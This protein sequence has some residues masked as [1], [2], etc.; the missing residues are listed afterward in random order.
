M[1]NNNNQQLADLL[2]PGGCTADWYETLYAPRMLPPGAAVTRLGPSPTGF[3]HLGNLF[4][5]YVNKKLAAQSDGVFLLRVEDTDQKRE[6]EGAAESLITALAYFGIRAEEGVCFE[7]A[8]GGIGEQGTYGPYFQS[9]RGDIYHSFAKKLVSEGKAYPCFLTEE[10]LGLIRAEQERGK[11]PTGIYGAYAKYRGAGADEVKRRI[12][13]GERY[14]LRLYADRVYSGLPIADP[15]TI[16]VRDGIRGE[17]ALPRNVMDVVLLKTDGLPTYHFAHTVDDHLMR[18]THVVRGEEWLSS[19]PIHIALFEA[20]GFA[21]PIYC[22]TALLMKMDGGTKRKLSKRKDPELALSYY[23]AEGYHP[24]AIEEYL[25]TI[26]N[27]NYE[28]WREAHPDAKP[29]D[30]VMTTEKMGV[31]GILFD[32]DKLQNISKDVLAHIPAQELAGFLTEWAG[33]EKP[34]ALPV[35]TREWDTLVRALDVGRGGDKPRKDLSYAKQ[36]FDFISYFFD[37]FFR[38]EDPMPENVPAEDVRAILTDYLASYDHADARDVWFEK[39]R[40]IAEAHGYAAKPK[41]YKKEP[42]RYKGHVGDVSTVIRVALVGRANSPDICEIQQILGEA[43]VRARIGA[44][45]FKG[46]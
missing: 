41:D 37:E 2:F 32:L 44:A 20:L 19:L 9:E 43:R 36:I 27:S 14:V 26:I 35:L 21:P 11:L 13:A 40:G 38:R 42:E 46:L 34:E 12:E 23:I 15:G 25:L 31:S 45:D 1:S 33:R 28:E 6:V 24:A 8:G 18:T 29:S 5:A 10:E 39:I 22:H 7:A 17:L 30:F 3:I 4:M 16:R